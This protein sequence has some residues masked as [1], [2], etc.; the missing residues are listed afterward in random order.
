MSVQKNFVSSVLIQFGS[1]AAPLLITSTESGTFQSMP[2]RSF[3]FLTDFFFHLLRSLG[4]LITLIQYST[5]EYCFIVFISWHMFMGI[6][7][8]NSRYD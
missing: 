5:W 2:A 1:S 3:D 7:K 4:I 8:L 6:N